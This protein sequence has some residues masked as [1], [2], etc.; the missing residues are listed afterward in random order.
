MRRLKLALSSII[1]L[2]LFTSAAFASSITI[3]PGL[4]TGRYIVAGSGV[5]TGRNTLDL[6]SGTHYIDNGTSIGGSSFSFDVDS[7]GNVG[8]ISP[9]S[10]ATAGGSSLLFHNVTINVQ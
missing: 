8:N 6:Q 5:F 1:F 3:D 7:S 2:G 9:S 4:Y 10:A